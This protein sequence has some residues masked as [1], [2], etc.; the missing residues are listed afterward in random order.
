[1][2]ITRM[3]CKSQFSA[4]GKGSATCRV[5]GTPASIKGRYSAGHRHPASS[6]NTQ[7]IA[8]QDSSR[9]GTVIKLRR[10]VLQKEPR[11]RPEI[12]GKSAVAAT[13]VQHKSNQENPAISNSASQTTSGT[14]EYRSEA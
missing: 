7:A 9:I 1:M 10:S 13:A 11:H 12:I 4:A 14:A 3:L 8:G 5:G 6:G 2:P